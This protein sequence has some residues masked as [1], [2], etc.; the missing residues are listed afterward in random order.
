MIK[1][2]QKVE[3][4]ILDDIPSA[5]GRCFFCNKNIDGWNYCF[6][7]KEFVCNDCNLNPDARRKH[8]VSEHQALND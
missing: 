6:G 4:Q 1:N 3:Q 8:D 2:W 5:K 7:C